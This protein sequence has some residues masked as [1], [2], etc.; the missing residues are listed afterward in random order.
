MGFIEEIRLSLETNGSGAGS[1]TSNTLQ[2]V[3]IKAVSVVYDS[4]PGGCSLAVTK[5]S[6]SE[7]PIT[8]SGN[9]DFAYYPQATTVDNTGSPLATST[10]YVIANGTITVTATTGGASKT[11]IIKVYLE[12]LN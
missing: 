10:D 12:R 1:V 3:A 6:P 4:A 8:I 5:T 9:T 7:T 2:N 11:H